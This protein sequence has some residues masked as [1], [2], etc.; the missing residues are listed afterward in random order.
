MNPLESLT[1]DELVE[2]WQGFIMADD[3]DYEKG[4]PFLNRAAELGDGYSAYA[5]GCCYEHGL[6]VHKNKERAAMY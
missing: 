5:L 6:G 1:L 2:T 3:P 4:L